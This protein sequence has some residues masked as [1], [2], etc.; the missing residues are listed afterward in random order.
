MLN[1]NELES[2]FSTL[3]IDLGFCLPPDEYARLRENPPTDI[4]DFTEAIF[5]AEGL[6]PQ[7][8]SRHLYREVKAVIINA[9]LKHDE[10][11]FGNFVFQQKDD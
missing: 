1:D 7:Y 4:N 11:A 8:A 3:C 6:D 5:I 2:L 9:F 10:A